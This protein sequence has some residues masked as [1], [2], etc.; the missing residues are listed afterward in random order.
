ME[1]GKPI[2]L[3]TNYKSGYEGI[4]ERKGYGLNN[5]R[6]GMKADTCVSS[7]IQRNFSDRED[8]ENVVDVTE[9]VQRLS[10]LLKFIGTEIWRPIVDRIDALKQACNSGASQMP[11]SPNQWVAARRV[12]WL[13]DV[14]RQKLEKE[15]Q[16]N[17]DKSLFRFYEKEIN[18]MLESIDRRASTSFTVAMKLDRGLLGSSVVDAVDDELLEEIC[19]DLRHKLHMVI[20]DSI[21]C[22]VA[23]RLVKSLCRQIAYL[24]L[25]R[26]GNSWDDN[27]RAKQSLLR[28]FYDAAIASQKQILQSIQQPELGFRDLQFTSGIQ[29][30][31]VL[32]GKIE[33]IFKRFRSSNAFFL[34]NS[35]TPKG[36]VAALIEKLQYNDA[37]SVA[38]LEPCV[39]DST[40]S[41][42]IDDHLA[43][44]RYE[45]FD[46]HDEL[47]GL[48]SAPVAVSKIA[49]SQRINETWYIH[50]QVVWVVDT[51]A[52]YYLED[53][54]YSLGELCRKL[55][56]DISHS[57]FV[58]QRGL[59]YDHC[60]RY[61]DF[62][63]LKPGQSEVPT[64]RKKTLVARP[65]RVEVRSTIGGRPAAKLVYEGEPK[66]QFPAKGNW[67]P[68]WT[69]RTYERA[70]GA[71]AGH[72]DHYWFPPEG[73]P[74][75]RSHLEIL[76]YLVKRRCA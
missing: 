32:S 35:L 4:R 16:K 37:L 42:D 56:V 68:G 18:K 12:S 26:E 45:G 62:Y 19:Y 1:K 11:L 25:F 66:T 69:Q 63:N 51:F 20:N 70:S 3:F 73:S 75:L 74:K 5:L 38:G 55:N 44:I 48:G 10:Y 57:T 39:D 58:T 28:G 9:C 17:L 61:R 24:W 15:K 8:A 29:Y 47:N 53:A 50:W 30:K 71:S 13:A 36:I 59:H 41:F 6:D 65:P 7:R 23:V 46:G 72:L 27:R 64:K 14:F 33:D 52:R 54:D 2:E 49:K 22:P 40:L 21:Y 34:Q 43:M 31:S 76:R 67:P 60:E